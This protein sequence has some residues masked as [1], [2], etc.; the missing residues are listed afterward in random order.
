[1]GSRLRDGVP[2]MER[3]DGLQPASLRRNHPTAAS[4]QTLTSPK[5]DSVNRFDARKRASPHGFE[6]TIKTGRLVLNLAPA[7]VTV[8]RIN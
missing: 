6:V 1:M 3:H 4:D 2:L 7:S 8:V 5:I